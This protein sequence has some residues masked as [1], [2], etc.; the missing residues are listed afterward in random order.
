MEK[1]KEEEGK[2]LLAEGDK[3]ASSGFLK[4][5]NWEGAASSYGKAA[6]AFKVIFAYCLD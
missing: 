1:K 2:Q 3:H 6:T 4:K 5:P